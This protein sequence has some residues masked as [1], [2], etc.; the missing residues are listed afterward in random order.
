MMK[1][2]KDMQKLRIDEMCVPPEWALLQQQLMTVLNEAAEEF[3]ER[4]VQPDGTLVWRKVWPGMDGSDDPYEGFMN[5]ALLYVL[6]GKKELYGHARKVWEG[7]TWQWTEYGQIYREFDGYYD[8]M[9]H[10][11][12]YLFFYFLGLADPESLRDRQR[13][14]RFASFYTGEDSEAQNYDKEKKLIRSPINGSRGPRFVMTEEDWMTHRGILDDY[15]APFEDLTGVDINSGKCPWS[16]D[17]VYREIIAKMNERMAKG[18]VPL[19]LNATSLIAHAYMYSGDEQLR[20]WVTEYI[21]AWRDRAVLNGGIM[22]DNVGLSGII[23]EYNDGKW[24]GGYYGWRWSHG[25]FTIVEPLTNAA[26]NAV[27]LTGDKN[28]LNVIRKQL[29]INYSLGRQEGNLWVVP[30]KH[31]DSGWTDYKPANPAYPIYLWTVSM[32]DGDIERYERL[33]AADFYKEIEVPIVSGRNPNTG[34]ETKHYIA[35]TI[36]WFEFIRGNDRS[37]PENILKANY[38]LVTKQLEKMRSPEGNPESWISDGYSLGDLSSIHKWQ[39]MCPV[40]P[41]GLLQ[42]TLGAPMHISHGGLQHARVRYY[43][44]AAQ[45]PGLPPQVSALVE[46]LTDNSVTLSLINLDLFEGKEVIIQAGGFGE[47]CFHEAVVSGSGKKEMN[48]SLSVDGKWLQVSLGK[49]AGV[50]LQMSMSRY[51]NQPTY[52]TP[53]SQAD[54]DNLIQG[55]EI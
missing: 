28:W 24:W 34:K 44:A 49:G 55:R 13:A 22:P 29:D 18:D 27:L 46:A 37:Y 53:W 43:D 54:P 12:G 4:Y 52:E 23:G 2:Q 19:N 51:V 1:Q 14:R 17:E 21:A 38:T 6:G 45:R 15:L 42:L 25:L 41:E 47:H 11:E 7:I 9:H 3:V 10:G 32:E 31:L 20:K 16:N 5:L 35:N 33:Q 48:E 50:K 30:H 26:M 39:E 8:W 40:Y 36:P